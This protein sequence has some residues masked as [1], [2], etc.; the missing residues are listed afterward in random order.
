MVVSATSLTELN[1]PRE[2]T[3]AGIATVKSHDATLSLFTSE[4]LISNMISRN[5]EA[6]SVLC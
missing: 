2:A 1:I 4:I 3:L 5:T 6:V